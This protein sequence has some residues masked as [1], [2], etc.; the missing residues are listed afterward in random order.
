MVETGLLLQ[1]SDVI[2]IHGVVVGPCM[3]GQ[4]R[5]HTVPCLYSFPVLLHSFGQASA[6]LAYI[7]GRATSTR[8]LVHHSR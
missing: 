5:V 6:C 7:S 1:H 8:N 3:L 2:P 4:C